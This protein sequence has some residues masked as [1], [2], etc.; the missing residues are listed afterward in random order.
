[1]V[2]YRRSCARDEP[3]GYG[4]K[5]FRDER[6]I[7]VQLSRWCCA[8]RDRAK[9]N[10]SPRGDLRPSPSCIKTKNDYSHATLKSCIHIN[11]YMTAYLHFAVPLT[12]NDPR[13]NMSGRLQMLSMVCRR[14]SKATCSVGPLRRGGQRLERRGAGAGIYVQPCI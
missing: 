3:A 11:E 4:S 2:I 7:S 8:T 14:A 5:T 10:G 1:M 9:I 12:A 6:L 13:T